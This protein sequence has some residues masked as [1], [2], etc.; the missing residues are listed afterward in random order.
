VTKHFV[1]EA[2]PTKYR[3]LHAEFL[4]EKD[5]VVATGI[6]GQALADKLDSLS[7][8]LQGAIAQ[9]VGATLYKKL[10]GVDAGQTLGIIDP[11]LAAVAGRPVLL[12]TQP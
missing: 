7:K 10:N 2:D 1:P 5:A 9:R 6:R 12:H 3:D 11:R 8:Q 4:N